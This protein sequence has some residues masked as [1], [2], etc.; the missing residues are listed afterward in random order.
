MFCGNGEGIEFKFGLS[1]FCDD[2]HN[3]GSLFNPTPSKV[4]SSFII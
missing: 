2:V 1:T 4:L 3:Y